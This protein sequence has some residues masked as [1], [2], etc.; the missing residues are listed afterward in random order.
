MKNNLSKLLL[1][2]LVVIPMNVCALQKQENVYEVLNKDG[3]RNTISVTNRLSYIGDKDITEETELR[4]IL[5][6]S[7]RLAPY[8]IL[9]FPGTTPFCPFKAKN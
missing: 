9:F 5:N 3:S 7:G 4:N 8:A 2:G 1:L 6:L